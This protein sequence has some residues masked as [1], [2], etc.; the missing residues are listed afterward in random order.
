MAMSQRHQEL[1]TL[2]PRKNREFQFDKDL[3]EM[4]AEMN[5]RKADERQAISNEMCNMLKDHAE[6]LLETVKNAAKA[7]SDDLDHS[8]PISHTKPVDYYR[9]A[10][11]ETADVLQYY[12]KSPPR[13]HGDFE[14]LR[15]PK[16][17]TISPTAR[18]IAVDIVRHEMNE[19]S[20]TSDDEVRVAR[21]RRSMAVTKRGQVNRFECFHFS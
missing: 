1:K 21:R 19:T 7:Y 2:P 11:P 6:Q 8:N 9:P 15:V 3:E 16:P 10:K 5:D 20:P 4:K 17:M 12:A 18:R 14:E 13:Q